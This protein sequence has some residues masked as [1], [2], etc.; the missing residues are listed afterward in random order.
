M[1]FR[2]QIYLPQNDIIAAGGMLVL[3][4]IIPILI[5]GQKRLVEGI[6]AG[7]TQGT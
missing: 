1:P 7:A 4:P 6:L 5:L 3:L 2:Q